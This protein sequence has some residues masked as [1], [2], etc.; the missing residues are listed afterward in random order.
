MAGQW[1]RASRWRCR[2]GY[3]SGAPGRVNG[4]QA[5]ERETPGRI[6]VSGAP[7]PPFARRYLP[8]R[9]ERRGIA[10]SQRSVV[11][12]SAET[13]VSPI[14]RT[15][16]SG[17]THRRSWWANGA[18]RHA[19]SAAAV[20]LPAESDCANNGKSNGRGASERSAALGESAP[21]VA[22]RRIPTQTERGPRAANTLGDVSPV[23]GSSWMGPRRSRPRERGTR[24][25]AKSLRDGH[26][27][28][29]A[30][31]P[32]RQDLRVQARNMRRPRTD[33][34]KSTLLRSCHETEEPARCV[35]VGA[36]PRKSLRAGGGGGRGEDRS[37]RTRRATRHVGSAASVSSPAHFALVR[38]TNQ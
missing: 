30:T 35:T 12:V 18:A 15:R 31:A 29:L 23:A 16:L 9:T 8:A 7:T 21:T 2:P 3:F 28:V 38:N 24:P 19:A 25:S 22:R 5:D 37:R 13:A 17:R 20:C 6:A 27:G 11:A 1:G 26:L 14:R 33:L 32:P 10:A 36:W 4:K 34:A